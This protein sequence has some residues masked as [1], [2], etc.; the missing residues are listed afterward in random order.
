[1]ILLSRMWIFSHVETY[2][3]EWIIEIPKIQAVRDLQLYCPHNASDRNRTGISRLLKDD[4]WFKALTSNFIS[5]QS[6]SKRRKIL[7]QPHFIVRLNFL[8]QIIPSNSNRIYGTK[9][10]LRQFSPKSLSS[11]DWKCRSKSYCSSFS[12]RPSAGGR[13]AER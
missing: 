12:P 11:I 8:S 13:L 6:S 2:E 4:R 10:P 5:S 1:M 9:P 3:L 7:V